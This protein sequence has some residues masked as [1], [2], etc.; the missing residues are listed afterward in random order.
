MRIYK[1]TES[2]KNL[3]SKQRVSSKTFLNC[4]ALTTNNI[5]LKFPNM[6]TVSALSIVEIAIFSALRDI[7]IY[8]LLQCWSLI[9]VGSFISQTKMIQKVGALDEGSVWSDAC[10]YLSQDINF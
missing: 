4:H 10:Q 6:E 1:E 5:F 9:H 8:Y 2:G 7:E 3:D